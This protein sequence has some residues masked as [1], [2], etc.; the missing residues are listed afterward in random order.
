MLVELVMKGACVGGG[1]GDDALLVLLEGHVEVEGL[2]PLVERHPD[3]GVL[4]W[5]H[6]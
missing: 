6:W 1:E 2:L 3:E 5:S 4:P